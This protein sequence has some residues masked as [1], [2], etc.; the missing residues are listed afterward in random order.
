MSAQTTMAQNYTHPWQ[1]REEAAEG[2]FPDTSGSFAHV[3]IRSSVQIRVNNNL[4][5]VTDLGKAEIE[6][7]KAGKK[8]IE[9]RITFKTT[10]DLFAFMSR[11]VHKPDYGTPTG[12][13]AATFSLFAG[14]RVNGTTTYYRVVGCRPKRATITQNEDEDLQIAAEI[15]IK[16]ITVNTSAVQTVTVLTTYPTGSVYDFYS[17]GSNP[18]TVDG[19][20]YL[21]KAFSLTIDFNT[22]GDWAAGDRTAHSSKTHGYR[23][24]GTFTVLYTGQ[25]I[26]EIHADPTTPVDIVLVIDGDNTVSLVAEDAVLSEFTEEDE[27]DSTQ[28]STHDFGFTAVEAVVDEGS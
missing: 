18:F 9:G 23:V 22:N 4:R 27:A 11:F 3:G 19:D 25:Q 10:N 2:T 24:A 15:F 20:A 7:I 6:G 12:T 21:L 16:D 28:A 5:E 17:G 8:E 26:R 13:A 14:K 1:F